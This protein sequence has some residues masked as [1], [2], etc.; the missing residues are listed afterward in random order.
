M[1]PSLQS[2]LP[3]DRLKKVLI[4]VAFADHIRCAT[5]LHTIFIFFIIGKI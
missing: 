2:D 5:L 1:R 3:L 4:K